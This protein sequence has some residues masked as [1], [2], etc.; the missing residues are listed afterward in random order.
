MVLIAATFSR[1]PTALA[2]RSIGLSAI[3]TKLMK[4]GT[5]N[6]NLR[7]GR[8]FLG[9]FCRELA[10]GIRTVSAGHKI[11]EVSGAF[12]DANGRSLPVAYPLNELLDCVVCDC[13]LVSQ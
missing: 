1:P 10:K 9:A 13:R 3:A 12:R 7:I 2:Q 6:S 8:S 5:R 4:S 11:Y